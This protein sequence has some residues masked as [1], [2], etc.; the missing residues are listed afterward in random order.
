MPDFGAI[1]RQYP[2]MPVILRT[3]W[4]HLDAAV[5]L[6]KAGAADYLAKPWDDQPLVAT[7]QN[8]LELGQANRALLSRVTTAG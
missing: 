3:A 8:L 6:I 5:E 2:D 4:I 1:R 7:V